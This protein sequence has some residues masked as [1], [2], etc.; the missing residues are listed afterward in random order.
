LFLLPVHLGNISSR[1]TSIEN[2]VT[3]EEKENLASS[4]K[5]AGAKRHTFSQ[6]FPP[7]PALFYFAHAFV[8]SSLE[9]RNSLVGASIH[10][11]IY[12][13]LKIEKKTNTSRCVTPSLTAIRSSLSSYQ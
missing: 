2:R 6:F 8:F 7:F 4:R 13:V 5:S 9:Q 1:W 12:K 10:M 3:E 11:T